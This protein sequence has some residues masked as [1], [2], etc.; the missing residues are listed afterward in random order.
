MF[1]PEE[2]ACTEK[3]C[4]SREI[5]VSGEHVVRERGNKAGDVGRD[6]ITHTG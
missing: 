4:G 5:C 3:L 1:Q 6:H 2:I